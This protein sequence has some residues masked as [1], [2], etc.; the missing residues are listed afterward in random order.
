MV[1]IS[2]K[3]PLY[4]LKT[5]TLGLQIEIQRGKVLTEQFLAKYFRI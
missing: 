3:C 1:I 5:K 2:I 4:P